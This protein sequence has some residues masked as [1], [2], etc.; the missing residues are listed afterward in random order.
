MEDAQLK[1][2]LQSLA[3]A[4]FKIL[5]KDP[6]GRNVAPTDTFTFNHAF[7]APVMRIKIATIASRVEN[8]EEAKETDTRLEAERS[9]VVEAAIVRTMK[10]R[11]EL[12][13]PELTNEVIAQLSRRFTPKPAGIKLSIEKLIEKEYLERDSKDRKLLRYLVSLLFGQFYI[14]HFR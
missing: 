6:V 7:T 1:R 14:S 3:C 2:T 10:S 5:K 13:T 4:K 8:V 12:P 11:K 9:Q